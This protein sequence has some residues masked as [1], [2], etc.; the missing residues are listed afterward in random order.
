MSW[1]IEGRP[2]V[3]ITMQRDMADT[4]QFSSASILKRIRNVIAGLR[5]HT[6]RVTA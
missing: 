1:K 4:A 5:G 3:K 2:S 6:A